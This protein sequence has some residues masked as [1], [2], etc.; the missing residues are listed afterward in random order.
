MKAALVSALFLVLASA[1][2]ADDPKTLYWEDL[3]PANEEDVI[4]EL[5]KRQQE[6]RGTIQHG[7]G[8]GGAGWQLKS[9]NVVPE[10][11]GQLVR[12]PGFVVPLEF[13][14]TGELDE[15]LLVPYQGACIHLPPPPPNQIV[16][17]VANEKQQFGDMWSPIWV[18]GIMRTKQF[19]NDLGDT[20]YTL[21]IQRW[22]PYT[23][24]E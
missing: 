12:V 4:N 11:D 13:T 8:G 14:P 5:L 3:V 23:G 21:E 9:F 6:E 15:F 18:I 22:E 20:A 2:F 16:Y 10:L 19:L 24:R 1:G 17:A 7:Y